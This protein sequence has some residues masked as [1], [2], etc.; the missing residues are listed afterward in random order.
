MGI[1]VADNMLALARKHSVERG[2]NIEFGKEIS[3]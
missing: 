2:A 1:D 3:S